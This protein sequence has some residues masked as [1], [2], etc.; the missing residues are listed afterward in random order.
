MQQLSAAGRSPTGILRHQQL[1]QS[2]AAWLWQLHRC[3]AC[4]ALGSTTL[5]TAAGL[6]VPHWTGTASKHHGV[7]HELLTAV[8]SASAAVRLAIAAA[9]GGPLCTSAAAPSSGQPTESAAGDCQW[10]SIFSD[11]GDNLLLLCD[12]LCALPAKNMC[13]NPTCTNMTGTSEA[14]LVK[15]SGRTRSTCRTARYCSQ[16]CQQQHWKTHKGVCKAIAKQRI[17]TKRAVC[18][19]K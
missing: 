2:L 18:G 8:E 12:H 16:E 10:S 6:A 7:L 17:G 14:G 19:S 5:F 13:N 15:G 3:L 1:L 9:S 11:L 4:N